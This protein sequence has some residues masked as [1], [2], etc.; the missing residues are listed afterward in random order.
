M[1]AGGGG[2]FDARI[3]GWCVPKLRSVFFFFRTLGLARRP[4]RAWLNGTGMAQVNFR[5]LCRCKRLFMMVLNLA[6]V[7]QVIL[8]T[9]RARPQKTFSLFACTTCAVD[10]MQAIA[11]DSAAQAKGS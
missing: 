2:L 9:S 11:P 8:K 10:W 3:V 1:P 4:R 5:H 7:A 6:Q